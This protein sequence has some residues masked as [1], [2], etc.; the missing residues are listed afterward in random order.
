MDNGSRFILDVE[1]TEPNVHQE[2]QAAAS[3]VQRSRFRLKIDPQSIGGDKA[4][5]YSAAA[6]EHLF[7]EAK[8]QM[9]L[10]RARL[11]GKVNVLEQCLMTATAQNIKRLVKALERMPAAAITAVQNQAKQSADFF[12]RQLNLL[13]IEISRATFRCIPCEN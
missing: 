6:V 12:A 4:Y 1:V 9:G 10:R 2:G 7:G 3:M 8:E 13:F 11:R 5:G